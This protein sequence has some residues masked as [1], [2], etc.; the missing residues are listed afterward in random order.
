MKRP[1][2][3]TVRSIETLSCQGAPPPAPLA[4]VVR[5]SVTIDHLVL[6]SVRCLKTFVCF[7][8][9]GVNCA[10]E[11]SNVRNSSTSNVKQGADIEKGT[12]KGSV[13]IQ[14]HSDVDAKKKDATKRL[15]NIVENNETTSGNGRFPSLHSNF[16]FSNIH[17]HLAE[18][19]L[20]A[21]LQKARLFRQI[22]LDT[23]SRSPKV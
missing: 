21:S 23:P 1:Y 10:T 11:T 9:T 7:H 3:A 16:L 22:S 20:I 13:K 8:R 15:L 5:S 17:S 19:I 14:K 12:L 2:W 18:E 4:A 6:R